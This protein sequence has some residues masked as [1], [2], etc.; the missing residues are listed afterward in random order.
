M[1]ALGLLYLA[2]RPALLPAPRSLSCAPLALALLSLA[3]ALLFLSFCK[4]LYHS[5]PLRPLPSPP[6]LLKNIA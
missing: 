6:A 5:G 1:K 2:L 4:P 3:L